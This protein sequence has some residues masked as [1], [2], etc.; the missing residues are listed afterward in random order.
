MASKQSVAAETFSSFGKGS[1]FS[2]S[3]YSLRGVGGGIWLGHM[4]FKRSGGGSD[5]TN[6]A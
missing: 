1:G 2:R 6:R 4:V 3:I 5:V